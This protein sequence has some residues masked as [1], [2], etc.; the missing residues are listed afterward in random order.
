MRIF[1]TL[2]SAAL[3]I[4]VTMSGVVT[5]TP[6][7][8]DVVFATDAGPA[9]GA[10][11]KKFFSGR[12]NI[13]ES[14]PGCGAYFRPNG[15]FI[16]VGGENGVAMGVGKGTWTASDGKLCWDAVWTN[17]S[18]SNSKSEC[19]DMRFGASSDGQFKKVLGQAKDDGS[20]YFWIYNDREIWKDFVKGDR[21][22]GEAAKLAKSLNAK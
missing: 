13:W 16:A 15:S 17:K 20:G 18:G 14:C 21:I 11:I 2:K 10:I 3:I 19:H 12:T 6:S 9:P 8:A 1:V 4:L 22:S 7:R 5:A